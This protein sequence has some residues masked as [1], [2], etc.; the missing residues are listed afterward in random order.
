MPSSR[1]LPST[2]PVTPLP[3]GASKSPT[4]AGASAALLRGRQDRRGERMLAA[5]LEAGR[6]PQD[7]RL[8]QAAQAFDRGDGRL[9]DGERAGL[10]DHQR[11]D[12]LQPLQRLGV[13]DQDARARRR[14]RRR[15]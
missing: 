7:L 1:R 12:L 9:A 10:V 8:G 5:A 15:P 6:Q 4:G 3:E 2:V 11:V 13:A 14:G